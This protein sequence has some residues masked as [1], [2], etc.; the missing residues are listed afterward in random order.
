MDKHPK[1][2]EVA[3]KAIKAVGLTP[4]HDHVR[5]GTDGSF[6][7]FMGVPTPNLFAGGINFHSTSEFVSIPVLCKVV[8]TILHLIQSYIKE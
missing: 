2:L 3:D 6:L 5:G 1:L 8:E 7:C 4:Y